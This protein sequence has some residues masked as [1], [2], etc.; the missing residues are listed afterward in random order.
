M[1]VTVDPLALTPVTGNVLTKLS[2]DVNVVN[3]SL[4]GRGE[5]VRLPEKV[6]VSWLPTTTALWISS[7]AL[8]VTLV[9]LKACSGLWESSNS[10]S[11]CRVAERVV[12]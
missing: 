7:G 6:R 12:A 1:S 11:P 4:A 5:V 2:T 10:R 3:C 9:P 8:L